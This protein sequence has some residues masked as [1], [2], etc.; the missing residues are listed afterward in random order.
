VER[1]S[2]VYSAQHDF[3]CFGDHSISTNQAVFWISSSRIQTNLLCRSEFA[4]ET[5]ASLWVKT[6]Y[7]RSIYDKTQRYIGNF[8]WNVYT[9]MWSMRVRTNSNPVRETEFN[10]TDES[11]PSDSITGFGSNHGAFDIHESTEQDPRSYRQPVDLSRR[12]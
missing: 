8:L 5:T 12:T 2:S 3:E 7:P 4:Y 6:L 9:C 10:L 1:L 11:V